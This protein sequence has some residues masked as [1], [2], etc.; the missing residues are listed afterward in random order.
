LE[1]WLEAAR[2]SGLP[3]F[4]GLANGIEGDKTAVQAAFLLP[5]SNGLVEG[6]VN[7][8]KLIKRSCY[9]RAKLDLLA[10]RAMAA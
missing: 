8:M 7:R 4:I 3:S 1:R 9:G 2:K 10:A 5:Y 6:Q